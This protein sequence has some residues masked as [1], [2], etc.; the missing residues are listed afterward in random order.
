MVFHW[1]QTGRLKTPFGK[2][3][4]VQLV[5]WHRG[6]ATDVARHNMSTFIGWMVDSFSCN[7]YDVT[8]MCLF[9]RL[10]KALINGPDSLWRTHAVSKHVDC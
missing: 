2:L 9:L 7:E 4:F 6:D 1:F 5:P 10:Y 8:R 3:V